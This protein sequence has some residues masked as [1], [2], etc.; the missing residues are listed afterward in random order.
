MC[1]KQLAWKVKLNSCSASDSY[2][3]KLKMYTHK[4]ICGTLSSSKFPKPLA[5]KRKATCVYFAS[6]FI[7]Q[8]VYFQDPTLQVSYHFEGTVMD[9]SILPCARGVQFSL[10]YF[11]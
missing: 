1:F 8:Y 4:K 3:K 7:D 2:L 9:S 5:N 11:V 10:A 6:S